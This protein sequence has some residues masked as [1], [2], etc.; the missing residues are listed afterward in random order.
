MNTKACERFFKKSPVSRVLLAYAVK[1]DGAVA[2]QMLRLSVGLLQLQNRR[3]S[4]RAVQ[5]TQSA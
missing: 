4:S 5:L 1:V 3:N 2:R